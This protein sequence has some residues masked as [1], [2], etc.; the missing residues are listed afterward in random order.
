MSPSRRSRPV[1]GTGSVT[2]V[3][4]ADDILPTPNL[5]PAEARR[6]VDEIRRRRLQARQECEDRRR[7]LLAQPDIAKRLTGQPLNYKR[8]DQWT[9][10]V[11]GAIVTWRK[12]GTP[13]MNSSPYRAALLEI[14]R[15]LKEREQ[16]G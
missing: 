3:A 12:N 8:P 7:R 15:L 6:R 4:G 16:Q 10:Y 2:D 1:A 14:G 13:I 11:P 5:D 9:G